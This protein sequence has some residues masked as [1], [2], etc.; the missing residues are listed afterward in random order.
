MEYA[1]NSDENRSTSKIS[2]K[3]QLAVV[4]IKGFLT[5]KGVECYPKELV[6][7]NAKVYCVYPSSVGSIHDRVCEVFYEL[8]G[9]RVD[10]GE[11]H[12]TFHG[13]DRYGREFGQGVLPK[14]DEDHPV[15]IIGH[16]FGGLTAY[17]LQTYLEEKRF[18]GYQHSNHRWIKGIITVGSAFN[19]SLRMY[20]GGL[21]LAS[22]RMV[23]WA[24]VG[25]I[26]V[27]W[28]Q[29]WEYFNHPYL[30]NNIHNFDQGESDDLSLILR[31][32][33]IF[34]FIFRRVLAIWQSQ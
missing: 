11:E 14:W 19:G 10:Y 6:P 28:I 20:M 16:S 30:L 23:Y 26:L 17:A 1:D 21:H 29:L 15:I 33:I 34:G 8:V 9:G 18:L 4:F 32:F 13:H 27:L 12:S 3:P 31:F 7:S 5:D 2:S 25:H 24:S 22:P